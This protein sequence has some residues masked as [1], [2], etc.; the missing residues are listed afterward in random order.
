MN[1]VVNQRLGVVH[2]ADCPSVRRIK[3][4]N[5]SEWDP[6]K[7]HLAP[8]VQACP[9]CLSQVPGYSGIQTRVP[10]GDQLARAWFEGFEAAVDWVAA[11]GRPANIGPS[12]PPANPYG[13]A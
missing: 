13:V 4:E 9:A 1:Y 12:D 3:P 10:I 7:A 2:T 6:A 8:G 11:S 5:L